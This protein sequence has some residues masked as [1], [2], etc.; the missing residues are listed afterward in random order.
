MQHIISAKT[1]EEAWNIQ[2]NFKNTGLETE[3]KKVK[4]NGFFSETHYEILMD[5]QNYK[6]YHDYIKSVS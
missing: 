4:A 3:I 5:S 6:K 1:K 2:R